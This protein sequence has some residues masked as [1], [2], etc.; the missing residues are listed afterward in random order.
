MGG[1]LQSCWGAPAPL[2]ATTN[3]TSPEQHQLHPSE[4]S[5]LLETIL[6]NSHRYKSFLAEGISTG[7]TPC[8]PGTVSPL[9]KPLCWGRQLPP[10]VQCPLLAQTAPRQQ[11]SALQDRAHSRTDPRAAASSPHRTGGPSPIYPHPPDRPRARCPGLRGAGRGPLCTSGGRVGG[12]FIF[13][14]G[15]GR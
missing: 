12:I 8:A 9:C 4:R 2:A 15:S 11:S 13:G 7:R 10:P 3:F 5:P 6:S 1:D 14:G